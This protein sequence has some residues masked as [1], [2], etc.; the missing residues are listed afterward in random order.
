MSKFVLVPF[1]EF[2]RFKQLDQELVWQETNQDVGQEE[3]NQNL[4][5]KVKRKDYRHDTRAGEW[6]HRIRN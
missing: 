6:C 1:K 2:E 4:K 3:E 5:L